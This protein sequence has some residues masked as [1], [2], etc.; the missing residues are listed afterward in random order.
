[1]KLKTLHEDMAGSEV[2]DLLRSYLEENGIE[3]S[4]QMKVQDRGILIISRG[5]DRV[6]VSVFN[7][8]CI[9]AHITPKPHPQQK[10]T[11]GWVVKAVA[12]RKIER[13]NF[14]VT[15]FH[16]PD[17]FQQVEEFV[18]AHLEL[19]SSGPRLPKL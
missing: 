9:V 15:D 11:P 2:A 4:E 1:M 17:S 14:L 7:D 3:I 12:A 6:V 5:S 19:D 8:G 13:D 18:K 16:G 10:E